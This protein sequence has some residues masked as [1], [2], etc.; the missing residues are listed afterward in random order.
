MDLGFIGFVIVTIG[1]F[2]MFA[3]VLALASTVKERKGSTGE[4]SEAGGPGL[5]LIY[6]GLAVIGAGFVTILFA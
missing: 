4:A 5:Y 2:L 1:G 6:A 3:G